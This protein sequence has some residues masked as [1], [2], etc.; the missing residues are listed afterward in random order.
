MRFVSLSSVVSKF[1]VYFDNKFSLGQ[2]NVASCNALKYSS[3]WREKKSIR[4]LRN[5]RRKSFWKSST[6]KTKNWP[7]VLKTILKISSGA[8]RIETVATGL[9]SRLAVLLSV[10]NF[11]VIQPFYFYFFRNFQKYGFISKVPD[12]IYSEVTDIGVSR[13]DKTRQ[14]LLTSH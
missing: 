1:V 13:Q 8:L 9:E 10:L 7:E 11:R 2:W 12:L 14:G 4:A 6:R 5:F 3:N